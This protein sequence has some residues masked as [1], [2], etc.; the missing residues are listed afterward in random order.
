MF[1]CDPL[2]PLNTLLKQKIRYLRNEENILSP[3]N[4]KDVYELVA[5]NI[6]KARKRWDPSCSDLSHILNHEIAVFI[7][8]LPFG[9]FS[10]KGNQ[11]EVKYTT[12]KQKIVHI[13]DVKYILPTDTIIAKIPDYHMFGRSTNLDLNQDHRPD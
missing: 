12:K 1:G 5:Q 13:T 9:P 8:N 2:L 10:V 7:K 11:V 3:E 6:K 4:L